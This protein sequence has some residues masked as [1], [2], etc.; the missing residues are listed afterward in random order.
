MAR[1][2]TSAYW[3][4]N[5]SSGPSIDQS[6]ARSP[7][8]APCSEPLKHS[9]TMRCEAAA[10]LS[11]K[12]TAPQAATATELDGLSK[13]E[14]YQRASDANLPGR[15]SMSREELLKALSARQGRQG[16]QRAKVS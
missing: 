13:A 3:R 14:L 2:A 9:E 6:Q 10:I 1:A 7:W 4:A 5:I 12:K 11:A 8:S 16:R 15:S